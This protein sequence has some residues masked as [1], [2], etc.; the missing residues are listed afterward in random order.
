ME[1]RDEG[2]KVLL[3]SD[4]HRY[5]K[6]L[7]KALDR[8]GPVDRIL[9]MGDVE[10]EEEVIRS[11]AGD[12]PV[13]FVAGNNDFFSHES[14]EKELVLGSYRVLMTHGHQY[15]V[16]M[17]LGRLAA[18]GK[19]RGAQVVLYGHTHRP[20]VDYRNDVALVNPGSISYPRQQGR[21]PS[22]GILEIDRQGEIHFTIN[23]L[24]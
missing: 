15:G 7:A 6:N 3:I 1:G 21:K 10:G 23:Y 2:M 4:T 20:S 13:E 9:H 18:E 14:R 24:E 22:F 5:L 8:V 19:A 12:V 16:S 17:G 11:L